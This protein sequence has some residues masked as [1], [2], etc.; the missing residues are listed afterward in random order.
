VRV[1]ARIDTKARDWRAI[2]SPRVAHRRRIDAESRDTDTGVV[3]G[4]L[5]LSSTNDDS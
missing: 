3:G 5:V 1:F 4:V 2:S